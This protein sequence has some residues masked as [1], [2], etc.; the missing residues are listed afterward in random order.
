MQGIKSIVST[1]LERTERK[2]VPTAVFLEIQQR[3]PWGIFV[4]TTYG[5]QNELKSQ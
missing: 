2:S 1:L 4:I 3:Y 5:E